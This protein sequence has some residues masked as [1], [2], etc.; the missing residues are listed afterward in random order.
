MY[1][2]L[3]HVSEA[4]LRPLLTPLF[5]IPGI[6]SVH[7][8]HVWR[9]DQKKAIATA[10]VV[11]SEPSVANFMDKAKTVSECL[12]AYG[13]H[14]ATIQPEVGVPSEPVT[15][16]ASTTSSLRRR[17]VE[18]STACQMLCG[19]GLCENLMCCPTVSIQ[20]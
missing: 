1:P 12:H 7:E 10:H 19:K 2:C 20:M 9:L 15:A 3:S 16:A 14:S 4:Q 17:R 13:I 18:T 6:E 8:L 5:Q 11:V